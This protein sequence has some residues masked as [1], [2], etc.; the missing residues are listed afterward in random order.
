MLGKHGGDD[1]EV[2]DAAANGHDINPGCC[3]LDINIRGMEEVWIC[4]DYIRMFK[5]FYAE[6]VSNSMAPCLVIAG[7]PGI[8]GVV[9]TLALLTYQTLPLCLG[10]C[11]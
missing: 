11:A 8:G 1:I 7:R 3:F 9:I 6:N 2:D 5:E 4:A 10:R